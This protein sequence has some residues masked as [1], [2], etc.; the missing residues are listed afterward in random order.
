MCSYRGIQDTCDIP[1]SWF[2]KKSLKYEEEWKLIDKRL[3]SSFFFVESLVEFH[4]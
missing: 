4:V 3:R 2:S 1:C